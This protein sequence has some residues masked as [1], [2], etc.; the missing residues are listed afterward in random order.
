MIPV[1]D[2][3]AQ[4]EAIRSE[5]KLAVLDVL[6]GGEY[7]CENLGYEVGDFRVSERLTSETLSL[8]IYPE[9]TTPQVESVSSAVVRLSNRGNS[10]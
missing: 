5:L 2:I 9:M 4:Y 10:E 7:A 8:S 3:Q 6:K 1:L